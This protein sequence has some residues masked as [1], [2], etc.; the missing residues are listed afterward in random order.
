MPENSQSCSLACIHDLLLN[1]ARFLRVL[2][3]LL[4]HWWFGDLPLGAAGT[5]QP[6][7]PDGEESSAHTAL[8]RDSPLLQLAEAQ[9]TTQQV[10][11]RAKWS[12]GAADG[13]QLSAALVAE[14][15]LTA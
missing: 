1:P 8:R 6:K 7:R 12:E 2:F 4:R 10:F 13:A 3:L 9:S 5:A 11:V 15:R 14:L